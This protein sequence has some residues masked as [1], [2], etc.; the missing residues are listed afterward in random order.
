MKDDIDNPDEE[1]PSEALADLADAV[2]NQQFNFVARP[3]SFHERLFAK[4]NDFVWIFVGWLLISAALAIL[5]AAITSDVGQKVAKITGVLLA[6]GVHVGISLSNLTVK[7]SLGKRT[8][9]LAIL[10]STSELATQHQ[11]VIRVLYQGG[12]FYLLMFTIFFVKATNGMFGNAKE[13]LGLLLIFTMLQTIISL[14]SVLATGR[15]VHD[16]LSD[17]FVGSLRNV[18]YRPRGFE[19]LA[20]PQAARENP[21]SS[22]AES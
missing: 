15:A 20:A 6:I 12:L 2:A 21:P 19:V 11:R 13:L 7:G 10:Q 22:A 1:P 4:L 16:H 8:F 14:V 3:A 9:G 18:P 17:T 5:N